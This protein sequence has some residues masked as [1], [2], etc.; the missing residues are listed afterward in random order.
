MKVDLTK[1]STHV[2]TINLFTEVFY[3]ALQNIGTA[4]IS[5]LSNSHCELIR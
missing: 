3:Q 4:F 1:S 5:V 2:R